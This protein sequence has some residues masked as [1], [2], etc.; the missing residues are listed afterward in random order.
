MKVEIIETSTITTYVGVRAN[1]FMSELGQGVSDAFAELARRRSEIANIA[2]PNMTYGITPPNY[3]GNSGLLDFYCC[4]EV[5]PL[6][7]L[8]HGMIHIQLLP[9]VY[10][11][12]HYIG[13]KSRTASAYDYTTTWLNENGYMYDDV[14]YYYEAYDE[15]KRND[16][17]GENSEVII[18]CPVKRR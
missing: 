13:P 6:T 14:S 3:K 8:P 11:K 16:K 15:R 5:E 7:R 17:D 10:A 12:T 1:G 9:R 18:Y 4:Y 2:R